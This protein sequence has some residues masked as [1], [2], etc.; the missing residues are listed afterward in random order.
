MAGDCFLVGGA[1]APT[2]LS[3]IAVIGNK[4]IGAEAPPTIACAARACSA[5]IRTA[6]SAR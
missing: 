3:K 1:S 2:L 6:G 4:S 5:R